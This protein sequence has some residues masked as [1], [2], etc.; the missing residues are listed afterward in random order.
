MVLTSLQFPLVLV[1]ADRPFMGNPKTLT[2]VWEPPYTM[3]LPYP[4]FHA[5]L[6]VV[7]KYVLLSHLSLFASVILLSKL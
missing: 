1:P 3:E 6:N 7:M 5:W 2:P 4:T